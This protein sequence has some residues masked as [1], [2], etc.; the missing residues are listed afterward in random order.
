MGEYAEEGLHQSRFSWLCRLEASEQALQISA[1]RSKSNLGDGSLHRA[2][3]ARNG[4]LGPW[5]TSASEE[6]LGADG[7][8]DDGHG[9]GGTYLASIF[10]ECDALWERHP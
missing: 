8:D 1:V 4:R 7:L 3:M 2:A 10:L 9:P 5:S 6:P